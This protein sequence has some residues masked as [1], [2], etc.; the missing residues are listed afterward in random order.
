MSALIRRLL[1]IAD[2]RSETIL[3]AFVLLG[4]ALSRDL[5]TAVAAAIMLVGAALAFANPPA[6]LGAAM[7][8]TPFIFRPVHVGTRE[9]TILEL[10]LLALAAGLAVRIALDVL[11]DRSLAE[12]LAL[13]KPFSPIV[14]AALLVVL[15]V[16][17][18][19]LMPD[20]EFRD[21]SMRSLRTVILEP[22]VVIVAL[23]WTIARG[24]IVVPLAATGVAVI[25]C[26]LWGLEQVVTGGGV[27][28]DG[29]HRATGPYEHPNNLSF[30]LERAT[31]LVAIPALLSE[32]WRRYGVVVAAIGVIGV[33]ATV[34]R[35][36]LIGLPFGIVLALWLTG[37]LRAISTV[38]A[39]VV[40]LAGALA[41][42]AGNRLFDS[43]GEGSEPS[44]IL[45]WR[46]ALRM[47]RDFPYAGIG[48][49]QFFIFYGTRYIEPAGWPERYTSHPHNILLDM[50]LSLGIAGVVFL[51]GAVA[52]MIVR[53]LRLRSIAIESRS[54]LAIAGAAAL[55]AGLVHGLV[56]NG[57]FLADLATLTW[58]SVTL[59]AVGGSLKSGE[60]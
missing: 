43:G 60:S 51:V 48:L 59:L 15:A 27:A 49:D 50:W 30:F 22:L 35:G 38:I 26:T 24:R 12:M 36:A 1:A 9:F 32:R 42:F 55:A 16:A 28:A 41:V 25:F 8:V 44:R 13:F 56:D 34:S 20:A 53:T 14:G 33:L 29:V 31:L 57:F 4:L 23:R 54:A 40:A 47:I 5:S 18:I 2:A 46:A 58:F 39:G 19:V 21:A 11:L 3:A 52:W 10:A 17:S 7:M 37:R 45:I 6:A